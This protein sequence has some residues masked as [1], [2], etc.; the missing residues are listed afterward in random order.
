MREGPR[1]RGL[2]VF[3]FAVAGLLIG[4][5]LSYAIAVPDPLHRDLVLDRTGHGYLPTA[6]DSALFLGMAGVAVLLVRAWSSRGR[7]ET[8]TFATLAGMLALVQVGAFSGQ[9]ILERIFAGA[10]LGDL[11]ADQ[12]LLTGVVVQVALAIAGAAVLGWL[13][14]ASARIVRAVLTART[15][16]PRPLAATFPSAVHLPYGRVV[17]IARNVRAPPPA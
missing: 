10:P 14:R 16:L 5:T 12:L 1:L 6:V 2:P 7:E 15:A 13:A 11:V 3:G 9:E 17:A 4:H 8:R